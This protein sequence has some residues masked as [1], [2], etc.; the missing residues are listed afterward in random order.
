MR[1]IDILNDLDIDTFLPEIKEIL[2]SEDNENM[3]NSLK[4][5]IIRVLILMSKDKNFLQLLKDINS[6]DIFI[7]L[8]KSDL[9]IILLKNS[10]IVINSGEEELKEN[11]KEIAEA[12]N[13]G[14]EKSKTKKS[15]IFL[16]SKFI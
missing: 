4:T 10:E 1:C 15:K 14:L 13:Y 2:S 7:K 16:L 5:N 8:L 9:E 6:L 12:K 11:T 3:L